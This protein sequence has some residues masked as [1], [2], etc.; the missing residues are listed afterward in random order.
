MAIII[1]IAINNGSLRGRT[2]DPP[3]IVASYNSAC[4]KIVHGAITSRSTARQPD[5]IRLVVDRYGNAAIKAVLVN[6]VERYG[7]GVF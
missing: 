3:L 2:L 1:E 6:G 4:K 5:S 7:E